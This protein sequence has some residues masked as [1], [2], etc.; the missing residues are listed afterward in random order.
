MNK[1]GTPPNNGIV[2]IEDRTIAQRWGD[3]YERRGRGRAAYPT[4]EHLK[5]GINSYFEQLTDEDGKFRRPP[6]WLSLGMHLGFVSKSWDRHYKGTEEFGAIIEY[7]RNFIDHWR[8]EQLCV[9]SKGVYPQGLMFL[10][11]RDDNKEAV[12]GGALPTGEDKRPKEAQ[13]LI[14]EVWS[15]KDID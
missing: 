2:V 5:A 12:E 11:T 1:K 6:S 13:A 9:P 15:K 14:E 8:I 4:A 3:G 10:I 7:T